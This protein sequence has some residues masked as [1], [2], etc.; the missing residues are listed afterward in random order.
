[1]DRNFKEKEKHILRKRSNTN[2]QRKLRKQNIAETNN[3][4]SIAQK[5]L[6]NR[7]N[8]RDHN[9]PRSAASA[10][11]NEIASLKKNH[12]TPPKHV[13]PVRRQTLP[14]S[15]SKP[16]PQKIIQ[17]CNRNQMESNNLQT[18]SILNGGQ[19]TNQI[20]KIHEFVQKT[21][22]TFST[23]EKQ[24][25]GQLDIEMTQTGK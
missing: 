17:D 6:I 9:K 1:M 3:D 21:M 15:P 23:Y 4:T 16:S 10:M 20:K 2:I 14:A 18:A 8:K 19:Q 5:L 25:H 11:K 7:Q 12:V 13:I 24:F 22:E